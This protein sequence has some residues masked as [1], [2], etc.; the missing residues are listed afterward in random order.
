MEKDLKIESTKN[1]R[2]KTIN[3]LRKG[4][5]RAELKQTVVEGCREICRAFDS[6]WT[7]TELYYCPELYLAVD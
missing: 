6:G 4:K 3:K 7:F 2:V 5:N 1:P